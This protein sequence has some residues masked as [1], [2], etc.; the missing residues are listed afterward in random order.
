[1]KNPQ[2]KP[3]AIRKKTR[4]QPKPESLQP[5]ATD[6]KYITVEKGI[7]FNTQTK[8]YMVT[9][10]LGKNKAGKRVR[11]SETFDDITRAR[12]KLKIFRAQKALKQAPPPLEKIKVLEFAEIFLNKH[13]QKIEAATT[14]Y[15]GK[16]VKRLK[17]SQ[18]ANKYLQDVKTNDIEEYAQI[19]KET[20]T[21]KAQTI[22][23]DLAFLSLMFDEAIKEDYAVKNPARLADKLKVTEQF[24]ADYYTIEEAKQI[25]K[26]L[27]TYPERNVKI[28][29]YLA[30]CLG[31]R[32]GEIVGLKWESVDFEKETIM[33]ENNRTPVKGKIV[34][35]APKTKAS[36]R[37]L[38]LTAYPFIL[39]ELKECKEWQNQKF[40]GCSHVLANTITG[41]PLNPKTVNKRLDC[42]REKYGIRKVRVHDLRH[43]FAS[44]AFD[45]GASATEV[46]TALGHCN[47]RITQD[48]YIH[49][50]RPT[51]N[52]GAANA[53][54]KIFDNEEEKHD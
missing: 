13:K 9:L 48:I 31:L 8:K 29:Y 22:N 39:Q 25:L 40:G 36:K 42:F 14:E 47:T 3:V 18:L 16:T 33:I 17:N 53:F 10:D 2:F 52:N 46:S 12:K 4:K 28:V 54:A 20:T 38:S 1:M 5:V 35:K 49:F 37:K 51:V 41:K 50:L 32:R 7:K 23:K 43:T 24:E 45:Q 6:K 11:K 21:L 27:A 44:I 30:M 15:Y 19:L 34:E 26:L